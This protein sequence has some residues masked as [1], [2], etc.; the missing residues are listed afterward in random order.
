MH[1]RAI[2]VSVFDQLPISKN[3]EIKVELVSRPQPNV[4]DV[5]GKQGILRWDLRLEADDE[6]VIEMGYRVTW[7]GAKVIE[8]QGR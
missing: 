1:E 6:K 4:R 3:E 5:D 2:D 7:P 8:Y